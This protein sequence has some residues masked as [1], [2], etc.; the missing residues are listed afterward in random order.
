MPAPRQELRT[1]PPA[2]ARC[3]VLEVQAAPRRVALDDALKGASDERSR[4]GA[5]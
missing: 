4:L 2:P 5:D 3:R 1:A